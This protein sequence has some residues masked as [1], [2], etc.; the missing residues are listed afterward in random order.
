MLTALNRLI[1]REFHR[2]FDDPDVCV[3]AIGVDTMLHQ[4]FEASFGLSREEIA[5]RTARYMPKAL[6]RC[7]NAIVRKALRG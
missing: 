3:L 5:R 7:V 2:Y 4:Y 1:D 6:E